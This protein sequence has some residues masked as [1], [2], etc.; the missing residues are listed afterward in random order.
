MR[1]ERH[2][3]DGAAADATQ[4]E[5]AD[6][7]GSL[8]RS[9]SRAGRMTVFDWQ[10]ISE[11]FLDRLGVLSLTDPRLGTPEARALLA[12][13]AEAAAGAVRFAAYYAYDSFR[14]SLDYVD[15]GMGYHRGGDADDREDV[16]AGD[17]L[18]AYCLAVLTDGTRRDG[19]AFHFARDAFRE[20]GAGRPT[21]E[22]AAGFAAVVSGDL[23]DD[24]Q[25]HPPSGEATVAALD[26]GL[27]RIA[28]RAAQAAPAAQ[29]GPPLSGHPDTL[30]LGVLRALAAGEEEAYGDGLA[31]LLRRYAETSG[32]GGGARSL[33]PLV[34]VALA[35]LGHREHGWWPPV[36]TDYLPYALVTGFATAGPRVGAFGRDRRPDAALRLREAG[37]V[38]LERPTAPQSTYA[39]YEADCERHIR[40]A[41]LPQDGGRPDAWELAG[42]LDDQ[43]RLFRVLASRGPD[44][45]DEQVR[46]VRR[47]AQLG[48][49]LFRGTLADPDTEAVSTVDGHTVT[50]LADRGDRAGL[51]QWLAATHFA[52][53]AGAEEDL[54]PLVAAGPPRLGSGSPAYAGYCEALHAHLSGGDAR[55]AAERAVAAYAKERPTGFLPPPSV[56]LSQ[57]VEG[58]EESFGLA[59]LDALEA[60]RDHHAVADRAGDSDAVL[61]LGALALACHARRRGWRIPVASPYLPP[62]LLEAAGRAGQPREVKAS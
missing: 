56:L 54:A 55:P 26:A 23:G 49:A 20:A 9:M 14:V 47:A 4:E 16:S 12:D 42:A 60:H 51:T 41:Y 61:D 21:A 31:E 59:L 7:I 18:D 35:A 48:A 13:A 22:L 8:T 62:R 45:T 38:E 39:G 44:A 11:E 5:F 19:E 50:H 15:F 46:G 34:P 27:A 43:E 17:W 37:V 57:L 29:G 52:L 3:V 24:D 58:D 33:L 6:R 1:I 32:P 25:D 53:I 2:R 40:A 36:D 10:M 28:A 30:A